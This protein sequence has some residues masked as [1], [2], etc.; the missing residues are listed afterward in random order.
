[1]IP[2][3]IHNVL[4]YIIGALLIVTPWLFGFGQIPAARSL[5][6]IA[7]IGLVAYSLLTKYDYSIAKVIPLGVHMILDALI[8]IVTILAPVML[9]YRDLLTGGQYAVHVIW[10][11]GAV[12]LVALTSPKTEAT[13]TPVQ[14]VST[15]RL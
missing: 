13:K 10:G 1:M 12:G 4:D 15:V 6:L 3:K 5:F 8:G 9:G 14:K 7:G 2:L 11:I